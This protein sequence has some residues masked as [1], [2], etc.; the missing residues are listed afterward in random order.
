LNGYNKGAKSYV[1][2]IAP[3]IY[4]DIYLLK[5]PVRPDIKYIK[6]GAAETETETKFAE[7]LAQIEKYKK[8]PRFANRDDIRF[9]AIVF[10]GKGEYET[11]EVTQGG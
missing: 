3:K 8:D 1:K 11:R 2:R 7:A 4:T 10:E 6:T 5:H 9:I